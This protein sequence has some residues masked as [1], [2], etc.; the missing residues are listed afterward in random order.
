MHSPLPPPA[1]PLL[2]ASTLHLLTT[3]L[4]TTSHRV[5]SHR[6]TPLSL[7]PGLWSILASSHTSFTRSEDIS[8]SDD[9][10]ELDRHTQIVRTHVSCYFSAV[11]GLMYVNAIRYPPVSVSP[12]CEVSC[13]GDVRHSVTVRDRVGYQVLVHVTPCYQPVPASI[14]SSSITQTVDHRGNRVVSL[15]S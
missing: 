2:P 4:S 8:N 12:Y 1:P 10:D 13:H 7:I 11:S 9:T 6:I 3:C 5:T 14:M 15:A